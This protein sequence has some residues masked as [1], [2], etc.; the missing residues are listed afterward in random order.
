MCKLSEENINDIKFIPYGLDNM[1]QN[2]TM[3]E[4]IIQQNTFLDTLKI[5]PVFGIMKKNKKQIEDILGQS[6]F[7]TGMELTRKSESEG[8]YLL[9]ITQS[10]FYCA[11]QEADNLLGKFYKKGKHTKTKLKH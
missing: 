3:R 1:I 2:N 5:V 11:Q 6:Q 4:I 7:F 10:N 8:K 9:V